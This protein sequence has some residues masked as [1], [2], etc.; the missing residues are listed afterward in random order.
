MDAQ[1]P[2]KSVR[3]PK[4]SYAEHDCLNFAHVYSLASF[5][6]DGFCDWNKITTFPW[7]KKLLFGQG[8]YVRIHIYY[9]DGLSHAYSLSSVFSL[10]PDFWPFTY[11]SVPKFMSVGAKIKKIIKQIHKQN[12]EPDQYIDCK[13]CW[14]GSRQRN[15]KSDPQ[16]V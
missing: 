2:L 15:A 4:I 9:V 12:Q 1:F 10:W 7:D 6:R 5:E 3:I 13:T 14:M 11:L 8:Y 16:L